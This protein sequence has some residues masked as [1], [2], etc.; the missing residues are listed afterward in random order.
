MTFNTHMKTSHFELQ[1]I[2]NDILDIFIVPIDED[3]DPSKLNFT[4][5]VVSYERNELKM[6]LEFAEFPFVST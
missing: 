6:Q 5:I 3:L 4:W 2:N 1:E